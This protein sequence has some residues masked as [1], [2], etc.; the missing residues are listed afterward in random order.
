MKRLNANCY[1]TFEEE[2]C[3]EPTAV[4]PIGDVGLCLGISIAVSFR[5]RKARQC[6]LPESAP[7]SVFSHR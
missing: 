2:R 5:P 4:D 3:C 7:C 1:E 6:R